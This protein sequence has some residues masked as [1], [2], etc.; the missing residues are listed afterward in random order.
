MYTA[1]NIS[2]LEGLEGIRKRPGMYIGDVGEKGL[3]H[4]VFEVLD[5]SVDEA[6]AGHGKT[7][8]VTL[9][10]NTIKVEDE[11]R[12]IPVDDKNGIPAATLVLTVLHAGGKFDKDSYKTAGGLHGIG[13]K[14]TNATSKYLKLTIYRDGYE[15]QQEFEKGIPTTDLIKK[16]KTKKTGTTIEFSPDDSIFDSTKYKREII[17]ERMRN[18][19]FLTKGIRFIFKDEIETIEF[20]SENG[21]PDMINYHIKKE[22]R[23]MSPMSYT[24]SAE[25]EGEFIDKITGQLTNGILEKFDLEVAFIYEKGFKTTIS[26]FVNK[27]NTPSGGVHEQGVID[28]LTAG[29]LKKVKETKAKTKQEQTIL[30]AVNSEDIKEGLF[31]VISINIYTDI[32]FEG[33]TKEKL[34]GKYIRPMVR[35]LSKSKI[36]QFLEENPI[37]TDKI[38]KKVISA[39]KARMSAERARKLERKQQAEE[40]GSMLGKLSDCISNEPSECELILVE[41]DSA[42]GSSKQAR[43]NRTQAILP[44][45]GKP[46]NPLKAKLEDVYKNEEILSLKTALGCG[47]GDNIDLSKLRYHKIIQL[48]DADIDGAHISQLLNTVFNTLFKPLLMNGYIYKA[49]PPLHRVTIGQE[50]RYFKDDAEKEAFLEENRKKIT[51]SIKNSKKYKELGEEYLEKELEKQM[52]KFIFNRFKGLGE[53]NPEQLAETTLNKENRVLIQLKPDPM[54]DLSDEINLTETGIDEILEIIE[55]RKASK[56]YLPLNVDSIIGLISSNEGINFRKEFLLR[57]IKGAEDVE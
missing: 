57:N 44:L 49:V 20:L 8:T 41:G 42:A 51:K 27:I 5:N 39:R 32:V 3:H 21:L 52:S 46:I 13:I 29:I 38:V 10:N 43:D 34:S 18:T 1:K 48:S 23:M 47:I 17:I 40:I 9:S 54:Y 37:L 24:G 33:Q 45:K 4:C 36:E 16:G 15:Y 19:S 11:G 26:S 31:L 53:M 30:D 56:N 6:I 28:A 35:E 7:I 14:A 25:K 12:G 2:V 55:K 22:D 50:S